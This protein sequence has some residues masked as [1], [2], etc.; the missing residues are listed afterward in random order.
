MNDHSLSHPPEDTRGLLKINEAARR[1]CCSANSVRRLVKSGRL[2]CVRYTS[3]R[4]EPL[5]FRAL[6]VARLIERSV[7]GIIPSL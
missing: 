4:T 5:K 2:P 3:S 7:S 1:L 6:D